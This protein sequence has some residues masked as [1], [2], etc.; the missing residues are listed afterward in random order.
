VIVPLGEEVPI[1][2]GIDVVFLIVS[3]WVGGPCGAVV[4]DS[5]GSARP[6]MVSWGGRCV[7]WRDAVEMTY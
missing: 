3:S 7:L 1:S 2:V 6:R 4:A 5:E